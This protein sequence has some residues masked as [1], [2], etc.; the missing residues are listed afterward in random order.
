MDPIV[1]II[2]RGLNCSLF[3]VQELHFLE[4]LGF[5]DP[6]VIDTDPEEP[7]LDPYIKSVYGVLGM[8]YGKSSFEECPIDKGLFLEAHTVT[9]KR[10]MHIK[11]PYRDRPG[12]RDIAS[13]SGQMT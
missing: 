5:I 7:R 11:F 4:T 6:E 8:C 9:Y 2:A 3:S 13:L 10:E 12:C 1:V